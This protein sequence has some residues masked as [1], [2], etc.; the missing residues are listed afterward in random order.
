LN[1]FL[2]VTPEAI[3]FAFLEA[4]AGLPE[5]GIAV[6]CDDRLLREVRICMTKELGFRQCE[7]VDERACH[8]P[9]VVMPPVR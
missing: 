7:E 8:R 5:D 6:T 3:E 2:S 4:N 1:D 9:N